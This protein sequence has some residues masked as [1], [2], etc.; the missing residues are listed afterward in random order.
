[1]A[2]TPLARVAKASA[3][4]RRAEQALERAREEFRNAVVAAH[5]AGETLAA[6]AR[7]VGVTRQRIKQIV[8]N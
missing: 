4:V 2:A 6:I 3:K 1:M 5:E 7:T 8:S